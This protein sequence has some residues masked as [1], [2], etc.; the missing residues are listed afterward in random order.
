[1]RI[2]PHREAKDLREEL[3]KEDPVFFAV[4]QRIRW[5]GIGFAVLLGGGLAMALINLAINVGQEG[6]LGKI[7]PRVAGGSATCSGGNQKACDRV[8]ISTAARLVIVD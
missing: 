7:K 2:L 1:H 5:L 4:L 8:C 6:D 3:R